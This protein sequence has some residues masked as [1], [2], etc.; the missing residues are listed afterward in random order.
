LA[1]LE[2]HVDLSSIICV[3]TSCW[4]LPYGSIRECEP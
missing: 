4:I 3:C 1:Y 2:V